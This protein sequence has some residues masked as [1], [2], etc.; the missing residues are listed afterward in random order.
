MLY[1]NTLAVNGAKLAIGWP[2]RSFDELEPLAAQGCCT[3]WN[4]GQGDNTTGLIA[5]PNGN[6]DG[7]FF[8]FA[9]VML[10]NL[11]IIGSP[12]IGGGAN[13][14]KPGK[15]FIYTY[16]LGNWIYSQTISDASG[17]NGDEF[18]YAVAYDGVGTILIGAPQTST[19]NGKVVV[20]TVDGT[21]TWSQQQTL[22]AGDAATGAQFGASLSMEGGTAAIGAPGAAA[23]AGE[24]YVFT[25]SGPTWSQAHAL[26]QP[27]GGDTKFGY[28][29][30][31]IVS[32]LFVGSPGDG[33][34]NQGAVEI[35]PT[36]T[37]TGPTRISPS[38]T[39]DSFGAAIAGDITYLFIGA[40]TSEGGA[41][42]VWYYSLVSAVWTEQQQI[43]GT[44]GSPALLGTTVGWD[45][46]DMYAGVPNP[47]V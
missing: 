10:N 36:A 29:V 12:E 30:A 4:L 26:A 37:Y 38:A 21:G 47:T 43:T 3:L 25:A 40:P 14:P 28:A 42:S 46:V 1:P 2:D 20:F 34:T 44:S 45:G 5:N 31:L 6:T 13:G 17:A 39:G 24:A 8:G 32:Y 15:A 23:G 9:V 27:H 16:S 22:V 33:A 11:L 41:G 7:A 19:G 35:Y 18:G